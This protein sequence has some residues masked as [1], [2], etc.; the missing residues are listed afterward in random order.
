MQ[1]AKVVFA[2]VSVTGREI[3]QK[4][5]EGSVVVVDEAAQLIE[6]ETIILLSNRKS[7]TL[8]PFRALLVRPS[9]M[10]KWGRRWLQLR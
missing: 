2:T 4:F 9:L 3:F 10:M 6:A 7:V 1:S 5:P 8:T